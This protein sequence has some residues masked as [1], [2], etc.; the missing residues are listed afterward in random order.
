MEENDSKL[1]KMSASKSGNCRKDII[2]NYPTAKMEEKG[3]ADTFQHTLIQNCLYS[4]S[5]YEMTKEIIS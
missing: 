5:L 3:K 1:F 2:Q 4:Q